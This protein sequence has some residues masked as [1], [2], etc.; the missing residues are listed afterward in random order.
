MP[1]DK[2]R[3][4]DGTTAIACSRGS[5]RRRCKVCG[6]KATLL[7]D[8]PPPAGVKRKTCDAPICKACAKRV[9][10]DRDLCPGCVEKAGADA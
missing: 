7:C 9:G 4:Q 10:P 6:A 5:A 1:C 8:G 2:W 3:L